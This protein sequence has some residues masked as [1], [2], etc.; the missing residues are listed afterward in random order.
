M[1]HQLLKLAALLLIIAELASSCNPPPPEPDSYP[2]DISFTEYSLL[3]THC[4]WQNLPY[5]EKVIIINSNEELEKYI[6]CTEDSYP[7][8]D[9]SKHTLL[10]ISGETTGM[11]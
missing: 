3:D 10:L 7:A 6:S 1:K 4:Q 5:D 8:I 11:I 2:I 9:F